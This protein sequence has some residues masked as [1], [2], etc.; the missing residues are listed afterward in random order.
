MRMTLWLVSLVLL[1]AP[2][3]ARAQGKDR[4]AMVRDDREAFRKS[5]DWV[6][7]DLS[8]GIRL[9]K[10]ADKPLLIV[11]R[12]IPCEAC[13]EFDDDVARRD[14][15]IRDLLDKFVCVR[16]IQA[17]TIDLDHFRYDFDQSFAVILANADLTVYGRYGTRSD[18]REE[19][20]IS[21]PGLRKAMEGA[22]RLH[23][24]FD[25]VRDALK[26][27]QVTPSPYK[28][29]LDYPSVA[30]RFSPSLDYENQLARSCMH[31]HQVREAE[32][33]VYRASGQPFPDEVL[34]PYPDPETLGLK[35]DSRATALV[36]S[37]APGSSAEQN[38]VKVGDVV[39]TLQGQPILSI[40][41]VQW[42]LHNA[43]TSGTLN[44]KILRDGKPMD[45]TLTL[46]EGWRR[47]N[48]SW[49]VTSWDLR[50][51]GLGGM[52]LDDLTDAE[53]A[54]A[55]LE[56]DRMALRVRHVGQF[57]DHA[58]AKNAGILK[59][60]L[61]V[62]VDELKRHMSESDIL[63]YTLRE[64]RKGESVKVHLLRAGKPLTISYLTQ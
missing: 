33:Q 11:F 41:D 16:I 62:G 42:V 49:R 46:R 40:A 36:E 55:K 34:Y 61:I 21:L 6:Y 18:R 31:C 64:K 13:Q 29:P 51:I 5:S 53:R 25:N 32:R 48:I 44:A 17:N 8:E 54:E 56:G 47:G 22:L 12:C 28:T 35:F 15:I 4:N 30:G 23:A 63:A 57:G 43:P 7:N 24:N 60:D 26:G 2:A 58:V 1:I 27:K 38:G 52:R 50:R 14:P 37:V 19:E 39:D 10:A 45:L 59:D 9:A 20:D 3:V